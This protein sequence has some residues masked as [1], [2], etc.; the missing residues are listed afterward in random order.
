MLALRAGIALHEETKHRYAEAEAELM[1][2]GWFSQAMLMRQAAEDC[3]VK[4]AEMRELLADLELRYGST[5][6]DD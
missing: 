2:C 4:V 3:G 5:I 6:R 1:A